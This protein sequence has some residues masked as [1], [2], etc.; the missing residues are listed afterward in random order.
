[1]SLILKS[2]RPIL[3][4]GASGFV[5]QYVGEALGA[6]G[7]APER[8]F[9]MCQT[10]ET[11][12]Q[13]QNPIIQDLIDHAG[14][15]NMV[16]ELKPC[17]IIHLAAI[18]MPRHAAQDRSLAWQINFEAT[19]IL[20][21]AALRNDS[22]TR[23]IFAGS[24][25]SYGRSFNRSE[26]PILED[27]PLQPGNVYGATK[28]AADV[29]LGQMQQEG[30]SLVRFRAFNH[31][32]AKQTKGYVVPDFAHQ[33][34]QI[35]RG[36]QKP[37]VHVGNL[38][39]KRDFLDV[40]DVAGAYVSALKLDKSDLPASAINVSSGS[41]NSIKMILDLLLSL[42]DAEIDIKIDQDRLRPS[43]IPLAVGNNEK[44][45]TLFGW[46]Q[47]YSLKDTLRSVLDH[48]RNSA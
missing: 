4:T 42:S 10:E 40:R 3:V 27:A 43:E 9:G 41:A 8:I 33:I 47:K 25:E 44:L 29:M 35:E 32:G 16:R 6:A 13:L 20:A 12:E 21:E 28:A 22:E 1:M 39:A 30:L 36:S 19:R 26:D 37:E 2:N 11:S 48:M 46:E 45:K 15:A 5:G 24:S 7:V 31:T 14:L 17:A 38:D 18:A 34:V 23:L